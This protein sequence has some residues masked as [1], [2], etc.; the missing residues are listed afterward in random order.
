M[1]PETQSG[2]VLA[3][4]DPATATPAVARS[5]APRSRRRLRAQMS[6]L[7]VNGVAA[8]WVAVAGIA[9]ALVAAEGL[10]RVAQTTLN[11]LSSGA[12][13]A[14]GAVGL[15]LVYSILK[16]VNFAHGDFLTLGGYMALLAGTEFGLPVTIGAVAAM[17][18]A[19]A[20]A[21]SLEAT[22]WRPMRRKRAGLLQLMLISLG[23]A[24]IIRAAIQFAFGTEI[25]TLDVNVTDAIEVFG[26]RIGRT[27]AIT[28]VVGIGILLGVAA[29]LRYSL[30]G[31]RMRALSDSLELAETSGIDTGRVI[32]WTWVFAGA[33]AGL[34]GVLAAATSSLS[35]EYGFQLL[36]PIFAAVVMGGIGNVF[37][38]LVAGLILAVGI[39]W[40]TM[41]VG[42]EWKIPVG[43]GILLI[44]L[45]IRPQGIFGQAR[46][47]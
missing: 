29:V 9:L 33:L 4:T 14:I 44:A 28:M 21:V 17:A 24:L 27:E 8:A 13:I 35:P 37:G 18:V 31:K 41:F 40:S 22:I 16:L 30:L 23:L 19:A 43:F 12:V 11:G 39:E 25:K 3:A 6:R 7:S 15:T 38:A 20:V 5:G 42:P 32:I 45:T 26:L 10:E 2:E 1:S 46:T 34:G 47:V 36:L